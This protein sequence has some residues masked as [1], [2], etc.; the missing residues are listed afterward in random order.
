MAVAA[1][2]STVRKITSTLVSAAR[3]FKITRPSVVIA[4]AC[5]LSLRI[6][7]KQKMAAV[8]LSAFTEPV[9]MVSAGTTASSEIRPGIDSAQCSRARAS[10]WSA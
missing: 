7:R 6:Q 5:R 9:V 8:S 2:T 3:S 10:D 1:I 4:G